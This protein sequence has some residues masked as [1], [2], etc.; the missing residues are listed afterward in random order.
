MSSLSI[1]LS[2]GEPAGKRLLDLLERS[3]P[4]NEYTFPRLVDLVQPPTPA[5][6]AK[7]LAK[8]EQKGLV[9]RVF[10]VESPAVPGAGI[11]D[12]HS[13]ADVTPMVYDDRQDIEIPVEPENL[14]VI[15]SLHP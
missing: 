5:N 7:V 15:Y 9:K 10:R 3:S 13:L 2:L 8:L 6:L 12:F 11:R 1:R 14:R 4:E